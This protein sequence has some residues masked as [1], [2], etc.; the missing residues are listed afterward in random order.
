MDISS[1]FDISAAGMNLER[2]RLEVSALNLANA[3]TTRGADGLPFTPL[4]VVVRSGMTP[5]DAVLNALSGGAGLAGSGPIGQVQAADVPA[6][7]VYEPGHPDADANG[8]VSYPG[9]NPVSEMVRL[10]AVTRAYEANVRVFNAGRSMAM[11]A[12]EIGSGR[13]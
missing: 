11:K 1:I 8:F 2:Q 4:Q 12:L 9:V 13:Q 3:N 6:R 7:Q 5:F 10:I